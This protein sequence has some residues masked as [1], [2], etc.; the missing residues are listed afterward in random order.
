MILAYDDYMVM[1]SFTF[2]IGQNGFTVK[3]TDINTLTY[4]KRNAS[5]V[6]YFMGKLTRFKIP[7]V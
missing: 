4:D 7:S 1:T 2:R 3:H 5:L 6:L